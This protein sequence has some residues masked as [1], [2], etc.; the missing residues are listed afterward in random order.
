[1]LPIFIPKKS[2]IE[3]EDGTKDTYENGFCYNTRFGV[4]H[5]VVN[6]SKYKRVMIMIST[7]PF[8]TFYKNYD[9]KTEL[10]T[11]WG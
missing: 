3:F 10:N 5:R 4:R 11:I 1:M 8:V 9:R 2:Y 7:P 6:G